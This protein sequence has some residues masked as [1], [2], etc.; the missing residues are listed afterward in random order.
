M[1]FHSLWGRG[2]A[3]GGGSQCRLTSRRKPRPPFQKAESPS[4]GRT[5]HPI[6]QSYSQPGNTVRILLECILVF[7]IFW[8]D[9]FTSYLASYILCSFVLF[10]LLYLPGQPV[11]GEEIKTSTAPGELSILINR[12]IL[13]LDDLSIVSYSWLIYK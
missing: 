2:S 9:V 13:S 3:S 8:T 7:F 6:I 1:E 12:R 11:N 4:E 5:P 10:C